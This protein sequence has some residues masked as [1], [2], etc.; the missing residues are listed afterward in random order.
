MLWGTHGGERR[1]ESPPAGR[2]AR[3]R[4]AAIAPDLQAGNLTAY[5]PGDRLVEIEHATA[6][7]PAKG[8]RRGGRGLTPEQIRNVRGHLDLRAGV[9]LKC[10]RPLT[11]AKLN[12]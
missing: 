7:T 6:G 12:T 9:K 1:N 2:Q 5:W 4:T 10:P 8:V 11:C 3:P